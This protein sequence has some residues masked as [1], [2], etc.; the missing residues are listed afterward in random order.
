MYR[1]Y[2]SKCYVFHQGA[3]PFTPLTKKQAGIY[4]Y[5]LHQEIILDNAKKL[6]DN[7][8]GVINLNVA[9]FTKRLFLLQH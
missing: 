5:N 9:S 1:S 3:V 8:I 2:K 4:T 7:I 6:N